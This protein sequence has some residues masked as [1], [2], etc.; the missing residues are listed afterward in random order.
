MRRTAATNRCNKAFWVQQNNLSLP[1]MMLSIFVFCSA[2]FSVQG[3]RRLPHEEHTPHG[4]RLFIDDHKAPLPQSSRFTASGDDPNPDS[5]LVTSLPL[6][7]DG[8]FPTRH[9]AGHLPAA[10]DGSDKK[11]FYW[12]FEPGGNAG[13]MPDEEIPLVLW[14][15]G[16]PGCSSMDGL[17]L[18]NG[19]FRL[20]SGDSGWTIDVNPHS[21]HNAPA[22]TM[23]VDQP[24]G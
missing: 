14:I 18:E 2:I 24:V 11:I 10:G 19:P 13:N 4:R 12:L 9:W 15:N 23:Y 22:W 6:L 21:W 17:W 7:P 8:L 16:G 3:V 5:H 20:K 1:T